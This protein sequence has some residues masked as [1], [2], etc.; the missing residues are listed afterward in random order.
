MRK[1]GVLQICELVNQSPNGRMPIDML[2]PL[3]R[4]W[5]E[6]RTVGAT[7]QYLAKGVN[8]RVDFLVSIPFDND[9]RIGQ[10]AVFGNGDQFRI[11]NVSHFD[12]VGELRRTDLSLSRLEEYYA[13][14]S[15]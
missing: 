3:S 13:V 12:D 5:F 10:Y 1:D 8:E 4:Y 6:I 2:N 14:I 7:R 15:E 11:D 9:I